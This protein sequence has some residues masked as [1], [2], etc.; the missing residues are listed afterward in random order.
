MN[1]FSTWVLILSLTVGST[2]CLEL[3]VKQALI[4]FLDQLSSS[5]ASQLDPSLGWRVETDPCDD[6]WPGVECDKRNLSV[7]KLWLD[8]FNLAGG[9]HAGL[10]CDDASLAL[11]LTVLSLNFNNVTGKMPPEIA[12][13]KKL[14]RLHV[15]HNRMTGSL[16]ASLSKLSNL[17]RLEVSNNAFSG[18]LPDFAEISGLTTFL[19]QKNW[20]TGKIPKFEYSNLEVFDVSYNDLS[21]SIPKESEFPVTSYVG[22]DKL[23]GGPLPNKCPKH[24]IS[25]EQMLMY[26]GYALLALAVLL[27]IA[28][29]ISGRKNSN[30]EPSVKKALDAD[31]ASTTSS[32]SIKLSSIDYKPNG[33]ASSVAKAE[34]SASVSASLILLSSPVVNGLSYED[35]LK[36]PAE[37]LGRGRNGSV[38]KCVIGNGNKCLAV[39]RVKD[40]SISSQDFRRRM[41][42]IDQV[43]HA[44]VLPVVAFYSSAQEKLVVYEYQPNG[45]L[46]RLLHHGTQ[47]GQEFGWGSR[48][49]VAAKI[50]EALAYMHR[51]LSKEAIA[52]SNLTSSNILFDQDMEPCLSEYGLMPVKNDRNRSSTVQPEAAV[53]KDVFK[54]DIYAFGVILL[55][56]LTAKLMER[57]GI[58]LS[59]WVH[60]VVR[61]EWTVEVFDRAL[62]SEGASQERML[63]LLNVAMKCVDP[64]PAARPGIGRVVAAINSI[65]EDDERSKLSLSVT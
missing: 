49:G 29:K 8:K 28:F 55:E 64:D 39:K 48:L 13:C 63:D 41:R 24:R 5:G 9:L 17:K 25:T 62:I 11:S 23:C 7:R 44:N 47:L 34:M 36:A 61:E 2:N 54:M 37:L 27:L 52:H 18:H 3:E 14:T 35:L 30:C 45:S 43:R 21:G 22:N 40:W 65:K 32:S 60:S 1:H 33:G 50:S 15:D 56:L 57:N 26:S 31:D 51:E 10:L 6:R 16:P 58:D 53:T 4:G 38:Y 46:A 42:R 59:R 19:A 12:K 20:F